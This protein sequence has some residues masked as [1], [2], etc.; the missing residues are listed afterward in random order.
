MT[1][2]GRQIMAKQLADVTKEAFSAGRYKSWEGVCDVTLQ[3]V[4]WS[5]PYAREKAE[6][7]LRSKHPRWAADAGGAS[8]AAWRAYLQRFTR[9]DFDAETE[10]LS[11][12]Y[13][14]QYERTQ[15]IRKRLGA[16]PERG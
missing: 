8:V 10:Y 4:G 2:K 11:R 14:E 7:W 1:I 5:R 13:I 15:A 16:L 3:M 9:E 12:G 6:A